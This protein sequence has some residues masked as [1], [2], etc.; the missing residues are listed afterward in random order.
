MNNEQ[1][2]RRLFELF[3]RREL[4]QAV[5]LFAKAAEFQVPGSSAISGTYQGRGGVLEFWRRQIDLSGGSFRAEVVSL[6]PVG[7]D[8]VVNVD[9]TAVLDGEPV[10]WRRTVTYRISDGLIVHANYVESDQVL[11][12]RV[13]AMRRKEVGPDSSLGGSTL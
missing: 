13:F 11:S 9:I 6:E 7:D 8:V 5:A 12:D 1:L 2:V 10:S 3:G 4:D